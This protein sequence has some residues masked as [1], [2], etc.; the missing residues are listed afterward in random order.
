VGGLAKTFS[1]ASWNVRHF[2]SGGTTSRVEDV[3]AFVRQQK[4]D[5]FALYEVE[6]K[7]VFDE[8]TAKLPAYSFHITEGPQIQEILVG[9]SPTLTGFFTQ[10]TEFNSGV[11][12]LRPGALLTV[13]VDG[14][15]YPMLF[16]HTKSG[17]DP[18]GLGLRD[19]MLVR[20]FDF[21][22][23]LDK[24]AGGKANYLFMGD[25]NT[26]GME[27][28]FVH[29]R[30]IDPAKELL[31]IER[32][33]TARKMRVLAK[34]QP[35]TWSEGS[36]SSIPDSNLD[37]VIAADH[38]QFKP[39]NGAEVTVKGWPEQ[40]TQ[41]QKDAWIKKYSDHALLYFEVQKV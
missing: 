23:A 1:V 34:D 37:H 16:L 12:L 18:R 29:D 24:A 10:R 2:K 11:S 38:L 25:L 6:G 20:A 28:A 17:D 7:D 36:G 8:V 32:Q 30:D 14:K 35:N 9:V 3:V 33:A 21:R 4:P 22:R 31:K 39:I 19:D 13:T 5:V 41:Q 27:Y 40:Q 15:D 26:M